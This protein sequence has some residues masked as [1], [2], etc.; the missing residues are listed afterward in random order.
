MSQYD[1]VVIGAGPGGYVAAI[2]A[3]QL[4]FK[5]A[6][7]DAGVNKAGNA[8]A[9]GGTCLNVGCIPSKALLQSSEHFHAAQHDFAEHGITVG[10]VKFDAAKM[11]ERKDAIVTKLTGG[12]KFLFQKNKVT[13]LFGTA[14]FAGKNGD[15]Y[16]IE[17]DNKGEKTVI[18]AKHVIVA[19]GSVPRPLP[20][21]AIDNVNVLDNEGALNLTEVPAKLGVIGSGVIGLEMGSVPNRVGAEV[22]ILEAAPTFLAAADQQIAKEAF[23]YFTKEQGL[24]IE[25]GVKIGDIKSEGKGVSV[26]YETAAGE[27]KTEVFDKLIV[28]IGRIPN[29]KGLNAEAVGLEK[30]ERGFIKVDGECRTNLPNVWAIGDVVRGRC[31]HTKPATKALP[32]PS[33]LPVKN[34][35]STSTTY[36]L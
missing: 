14:S 36:R 8:P 12:V 3:A 31:W 20:Q 33:A 30:D 16:Q 19:T 29:T 26:A 6:C 32:L 18:E 24:S 28:A 22:T 7:V 11:I 2:R 15:A 9:L 5:T 34:R 17:V 25:L 13:S 27:A 10:D 1:V 35:I 4:G 21:V 23:K